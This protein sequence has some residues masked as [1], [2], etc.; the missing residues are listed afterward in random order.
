MRMIV[1][2]AIAAAVAIIGYGMKTVFR[3]GSSVDLAAISA[4][5]AAVKTLSP[6]DIHLNYQNMRELP[7]HEIKEP[8]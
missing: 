6:H 1:V 7:V 4:D 3:P 5:I 2:F 8:F